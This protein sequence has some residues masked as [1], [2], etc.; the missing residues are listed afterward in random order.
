MEGSRDSANTN[1]F[2]DDIASDQRSPSEVLEAEMR[3]KSEEVVPDKLLQ[4]ETLHPSSEKPVPE[5]IVEEQRDADVPN[6]GDDSVLMKTHDETAKYAALFVRDPPDNQEA[7]AA[8]AESIGNVS[9][10]ALTTCPPS[11]IPVDSDL[12]ELQTEGSIIENEAE[13]KGVDCEQQVVCEV[14]TEYLTEGKPDVIEGVQ[15]PIGEEQLNL[16]G[17]DT[18]Q[19]FAAGTGGEDPEGTAA[20]DTQE[21]ADLPSLAPDVIEKIPDLPRQA[22][23]SVDSGDVQEAVQPT[24]PT[25]NT[26]L[27]FRY[28]TPVGLTAT[29][30][31]LAAVVI[32]T[33]TVGHL[34]HKEE[35]NQ[36]EG[37][38]KA[39]IFP[40]WNKSESNRGQLMLPEDETEIDILTLDIN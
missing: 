28:K 15:D 7:Q 10:E 4:D 19:P 17:P 26:E 25:E 27:V 8:D 32:F 39:L 14:K 9:G 16:D 5:L 33:V 18:Q 20:T 6:M 34:L 22:S 11:T 30:L 36:E 1:N 3:E 24:A 2:L 12:V 13:D 35:E 21:I 31:F 37:G 23:S 38:T 40:E 29:L